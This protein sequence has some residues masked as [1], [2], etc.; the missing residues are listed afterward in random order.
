M[1]HI[2][3]LNKNGLKNSIDCRAIDSEGCLMTTT[4]NAFDAPRAI[5]T[6]LDKPSQ[7]SGIQSA[8]IYSDRSLDAYNA[9]SFGRPYSYPNN[10]QITYYIDES[11]RQPFF[12][13]LFIEQGRPMVYY[14]DYTD[15][16]S[17]WKPHYILDIKS[18][19]EISSY[20]WI[21]DS[22]FHRQDL[23]SKQMAVR[24]Q[25]KSQPFL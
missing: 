20:S 6:R 13:P 11:I 3:F 18:P 4:P 23:M 22:T 24:N 2:R 15:P 10:A 8:N 25:Q 19:S 14:E 9:G 21:V 7:V 1:N 16:M 5:H 17:S 12:E